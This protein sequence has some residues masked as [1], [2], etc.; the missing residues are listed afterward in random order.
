MSNYSKK[1][2]IYA[3]YLLNKFGINDYQFIDS[4]LHVYSI[5]Y[6]YYQKYPSGTY[7]NSS[8]SITQLLVEKDIRTTRN[9]I[10][11]KENNKKHI[12]ATDLSKYVFCSA[13][14]CISNTF[15][16]DYPTGEKQRQIG[17]NLHSKLN[18]IKKIENY[19]R[20][21]QI[22]E[23]TSSN[24]YLKNI[25][26]SKLIYAGHSDNF[27]KQVFYNEVT[28]IAS[29]PDYIFL[30]SNNTYFIVEEKYHYHKDPKKQTFNE[31]WMEWN[32]YGYGVDEDD[33]DERVNEL[34]EKSNIFFNNH[35]IQVLTYIKNIKKYNIQ[36]GYLVYWYYDF[37]SSEPYIHKRKIKK[38]ALSEYYEKFYSKTLANFKS[39]KQNKSEEFDIEKINPNKCANCVVNKYCG[40]KNKKF[41][42]LSLPYN[43]EYLQFFPVEFPKELKK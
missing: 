20:D 10:K 13:S 12:N 6:G 32:G 26:N 14:Y 30:D 36:Y 8:E 39:L 16:I 34:E 33:Y 38:I 41:N 22:E 37:N 4:F 31:M 2:E 25:F 11:L 21:K 17:E 15:I 35:I 1:Q 19:Q 40:H 27:E 28:N 3:T 43:T 42:D 23:E 18:L 5:L 7:Y 24:D 29:E 9:L